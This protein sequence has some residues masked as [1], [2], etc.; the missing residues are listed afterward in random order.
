M[1]LDPSTLNVVL[2][3]AL[4]AMGGILYLLPVGTCS[5]CAHCRL[6]R[7]Q[8]ERDLEERA[9]RFYGIPQCPACG[10]HHDPREDHPA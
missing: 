6:V 5:E 2:G 3:V 7:L 4:L 8:R 10:R 1:V 9:A